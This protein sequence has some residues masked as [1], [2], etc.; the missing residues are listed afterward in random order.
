M[1]KKSVMHV[2]S[3]CF[4]NQTYWFFC[5]SRRRPRRRCLRSLLFDPC[6]C[7]HNAKHAGKQLINYQG[8]WHANLLLRFSKTHESW[9]SKAN[10]SLC[11][12]LPSIIFADLV[13]NRNACFRWLTPRFP[14]FS[15]R[16]SSWRLRSKLLP[17]LKKSCS[18]QK[19]TA[20]INKEI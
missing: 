9:S 16:C 11:F 7:L 19:Q 14:R 1:Y 18:H 3:C 4:A 5:R 13:G 6:H 17:K 8:N 15:W 10:W 12:S 2:Q 20:V